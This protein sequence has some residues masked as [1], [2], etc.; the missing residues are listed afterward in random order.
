MADFFLVPK[1]EL[2][3][4]HRQK[5][6]GWWR[7]YEYLQKEISPEILDGYTHSIANKISAQIDCTTCGRCCRELSPHMTSDDVVRLAFACGLSTQVVFQRWLKPDPQWD[8]EFILRKSPCPMLRYGLC[9]VYKDRPSDCASYP[10]LQQPSILTY[11]QSLIENARICSIVFHTL[12][13]LQSEIG[14]VDSQS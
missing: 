12:E 7:F 8:D 5:W 13:N 3:K 2:E 10:H 9:T 14:W 6:D 11:F 1:E 4:L